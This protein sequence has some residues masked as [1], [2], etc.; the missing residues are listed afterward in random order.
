VGSSEAHRGETR[1]DLLEVVVVVC[2]A[3]LALVFGAVVVRVADERTLPLV[4]LL[5][6]VLVK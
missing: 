3:E 5:E 6:C 2:H 1:V 4:V